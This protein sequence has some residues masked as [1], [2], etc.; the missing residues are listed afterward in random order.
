[1]NV[2]RWGVRSL[3]TRRAESPCGVSAPG[4]L[5]NIPAF[6]PLDLSRGRNAG[7][8]AGG[9]STRGCRFLAYQ[10]EYLNLDEQHI[11][12]TFKYKLMPTPKQEGALETLVYRV[13]ARYKIALEQ[14]KTWWQRGQGIGASYYQQQAELPDLKAACPD[15]AAINAQVLQDVLLRVERAYQAF[16]RRVK[17]GETPGHPRFQGKGRDHRF[18]YPQDGGGAVLDG[19]VLSR[20]KIGRILIR[21]HRPLQG[22]PKTVT[23]SREADG[24]YACISCAEVPPEPL[25]LTGNETGIDV[26]LKGFLITAD[27]EIIENPRQYQTAETHLVKAQRRVSRRKKG[28]K[29]RKKGSKRRKKGSKLLAR[30][31]QQVQRQRTDFHHKTALS[32]LRTYDVIYLEDLQVRNMVRNHHLAKSISDAGWAAFRSLLTSK[33]AYAGK[34]VVAVPPAFTSQDCSGC[35]ERV[36]KSLSVCTHACPSWG[37]VIDRDENAALNI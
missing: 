7:R 25:P 24:W 18:T 5:A 6:L 1:V 3:R 36:P 20:S 2:A 26:G 17:A 33:A 15:S 12:K 37:L 34:W 30:K 10:A 27:G 19:G 11:R 21:L 8:W 28:S 29:R 14:R 35:G 31:H 13:R 32:L 22:T 9:E 16:F 23:I 4:R